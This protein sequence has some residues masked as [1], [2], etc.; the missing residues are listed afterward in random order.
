MEC[1]HNVFDMDRG[2]VYVGE[3]AAVD[4]KGMSLKLPPKESIV[5]K[6]KVCSYKNDIIVCSGNTSN[7]NSA[8]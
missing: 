1:R 6:I 5:Y 8:W 2:R 4:C 7:G 3:V